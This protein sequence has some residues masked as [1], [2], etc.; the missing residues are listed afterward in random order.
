MEEL[1][2]FEDVVTMRR[3]AAGV[4][5]V[6]YGG[7]KKNMVEF[8][9]DKVFMEFLSKKEGRKIYEARDF[10]RTYIPGNK[11]SI[12]VR[13]VTE[14]DKIQ[15]SKE[16]AAYQSQHEQIPDGIPLESCLMLN[17]A[18]VANLKALRIHTIEQLMEM[19]DGNV[20]NL[21]LGMV[22]LRNKVRQWYEGTHKASHANQQ[23]ARIEQLERDILALRNTLGGIPPEQRLESKPVEVKPKRKYMRKTSTEDS[24]GTSS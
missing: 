11:L 24:N 12:F 21:G 5:E 14:Q 1:T 20:S 23:Q 4:S 15:Y 16:W 3:V 9:Q 2:D 22:T 8:F 17:V 7:T 18:D 10:L 6:Q 13:A 19:P